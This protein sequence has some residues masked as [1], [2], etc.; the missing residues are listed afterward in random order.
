MAQKLLYGYCQRLQLVARKRIV[1]GRLLNIFCWTGFSF[2]YGE[3][4]KK[5][6]KKIKLAGALATLGLLSAMGTAQATIF[7]ID[8]NTLGAFSGT[9]PGSPSP[10]TIFATAVFDDHGGSGSVTLTMSVLSTLPSGSYVNDWYF[11]VSSAPLAAGAINFVS[12]VEALT[13]DNGSNAFKADGTGGKFDLAYSFSNGDG[14]L[15]PAHTSVYTITGA[16]LTASSFNSLSVPAPNGGNY[17]SA[18]HLQGYDGSSVW[19]AGNGITRVPQT[20]AEIPEPAT[21]ALLGLGLFGVA[22][23]RRRLS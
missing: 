2:F 3:I 12:G 13:V 8:F 7:E 5:S 9:A 21:L 15:G 16:G 6:F 1:A 23:T 20:P 14:E 11:N 22:A 18:L 10:S 17:L 4:M 19:V